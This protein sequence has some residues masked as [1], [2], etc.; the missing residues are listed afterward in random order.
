MPADS[1]PVPMSEQHALVIQLC[2]WA[3]VLAKPSK[4]AFDD[5][6][7][8]ILSAQFNAF[9]IR[10]PRHIMPIEKPSIVTAIEALH[11]V[12]NKSWRVLA[13]VTDLYILHVD[14]PNR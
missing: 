5:V 12:K 10:R 2:P 8:M 4:P 3:T 14:D 13:S 9:A 1:R 7:M 11:Y 6:M